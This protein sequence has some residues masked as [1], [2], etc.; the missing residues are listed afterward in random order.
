MKRLRETLKTRLELAQEELSRKR[1][2]LVLCQSD[3]N[4]PRLARL[5]ADAVDRLEDEIARLRQ[6]VGGES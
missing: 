1:V 6:E 2:S 3:G 4:M 5:H